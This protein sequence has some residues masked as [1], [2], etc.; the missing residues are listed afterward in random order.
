[1]EA[2][3]GSSSKLQFGLTVIGQITPQNILRE[4]AGNGEKRLRAY[5]NAELDWASRMGPIALL[6]QYPMPSEPVRAKLQEKYGDEMRRKLEFHLAC[7]E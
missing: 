4:T 1:L 2:V 5:I 3:T 6:V 7:T